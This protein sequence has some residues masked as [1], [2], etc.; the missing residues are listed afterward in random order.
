LKNTEIAAEVLFEG[1]DPL[2]SQYVERE[3]MCAQNGNISYTSVELAKIDIADWVLDFL[4][5]KPDFPPARME[6][7]TAPSSKEPIPAKLRW[8]VW[9]RDNFTCKRCGVRRDLAVDHIV[10]ESKGG[11]LVP[12]NLQ[13]LCRV[14]NSI[15]GNR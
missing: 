14:C 9:L 2:L 11:E 13:T 3:A 7:S 5:V 10:P 1:L 15:K 12:E 8:E 4:G 6:R